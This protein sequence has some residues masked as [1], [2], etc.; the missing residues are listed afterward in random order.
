MIPEERL[1]DANDAPVVADGAHV[2]Y[3]MIAARRARYS[4][5]L[6]RAVE[7]AERLGRPL[8]V[9]EALRCGYPHAS[10]RLH[11]F[12]LDGFADNAAALDRP[13]VRYHPYLERAA[14][15]G[16]GLLAALAARACVV[17][18]DDYPT[19]FLPRMVAAAA[20][21]LAVRLE[22]VDGNGLLPMRDPQRVFVRAVDLRRH[23]QRTL[24]GGLVLPRADPLHGAALPEGP[25]ALPE[26]V[27]RR[28]PA[29][30]VADLAPGRLDL[31]TLPID[32]AVAPTALRG[33]AAAG[34]ARLAAFLDG[35]LE[36]YADDHDHPDR[37]AASG[38]SPYLHF[39]QLAAHEVFAEL[40]RHE[41]WSPD[42]VAGDAR[43]RREGWWGMGPGA[44]AFVDQL[45]TWRELGYRTAA[46]RPDHAAYD[47]L[48]TW[49]RKTLQA[50]A[51]D[52]REHRYD[53]SQLEAAE[54]HDPLW[55]A[56]QRQLREEGAIQGYLRM[57]WGKKI[58]QW[59]DTPQQAQALALRLNDRHAL[60]GRDP[61]SVSGVQWVFGLYDRPWFPE[62]PV[63]GTVRYMTSQSAARK[64]RLKQYLARWSE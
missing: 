15:E 5:A 48:P 46:L 61:N 28:W 40:T 24:P 32:H 36:R 13:G 21:R 17:V 52:P 59:S 43:G 31:G 3:W 53:P 49:A 30:P 26:E 34:R 60:D 55:N 29:T 14:G 1:R 16:S 22:Q 20:A 10:D 64:L 35:P 50:H 45:V 39:G 8:V 4:F 27:T 23:L 47:E 9:L 38:L 41:G 56:A 44:E 12:V 62:R 58:L 42:A 54:T 51:A 11:R 7:W 37:D 6:Q 19:F 2:L 33:G 57:L 63:F 25:V 18:T